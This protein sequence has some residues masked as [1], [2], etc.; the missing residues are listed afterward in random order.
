M[1][2]QVP[3]DRRPSQG[4]HIVELAALGFDGECSL[5]PIVSLKTAL[6]LW[7]EYLNAGFLT[8][9]Y[10]LL[11]TQPPEPMS[12][13]S[14]DDAKLDHWTS[15]S[16]ILPLSIFSLGYVKGMAR[17]CLALFV[18]TMC[19]KKN[20]NLNTT[21]PMLRQSMRAVWVIHETF[22]ANTL[23]VLIRAAK[24][25]VRDRTRKPYN[26][27]EWVSCLIKLKDE[28]D[29]TAIIKTWNGVCGSEHRLQGRT[30]QAVSCI[31]KNPLCCV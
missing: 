17:A 25:S 28:R 18:A 16:D 1:I 9:E 30:Y 12:E 19:P 22:T 29:V 20:A 26:C 24:L 2:P 14:K 4:V 10:P 13:S 21:H 31:L 23:S 27:L 7:A 8:Y 6:Q 3:E 5:K 15:A 11:V